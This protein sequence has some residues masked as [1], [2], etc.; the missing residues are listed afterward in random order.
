MSIAFPVSLKSHL[1]GLRLHLVIGMAL[2]AVTALSSVPVALAK[3]PMQQTQ[4]P[5]FYRTMIGTFEIT[6][7][8]DGTARMPIDR[9]LA[10][11]PEK[12]RETLRA[13]YLDTPMEMSVN[14]YLINTGDR[15]V[16]VDTGSGE[17]AGPD[18]GRLADNIIASGHTPD[19]VDDVLLTHLH[20]DHVG[21]LVANGTA[22]FPSAQVHVSREEAGFWRS[23]TDPSAMGNQADFAADVR[24]LLDPYIASGQFQPFDADDEVV[25]GVRNMAAAGHTPGSVVYI[26]ESGGEQL[27]LIGDLIHAGPVQFADPDVTFAFDADPPKA[28]AI[29]RDIF[30]LA[31]SER[32]LIGAA[33]LPF[34][35]LGYLRS[36]SGA[37][38]W[39]SINYSSAME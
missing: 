21:G 16:L 38:H 2:S 19:Q 6:A 10:D 7:L 39:I 26:V 14:A 36:E 35:G 22:L 15:L 29:R 1:S 9:L 30:E 8:S 18:L 37:S 23:R 28:A 32:I 20:P 4:A 25:A 5:G 27:Y 33:H 34:P 11:P 13:A 3:A 24:T 31:A 12:T 17:G